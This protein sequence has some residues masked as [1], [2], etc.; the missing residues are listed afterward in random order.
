MYV[1]IIFPI[2]HLL[3]RRNQCES[4]N[5]LFLSLL[6]GKIIAVEGNSAVTKGADSLSASSCDNIAYSGF[7]G[8][9]VDERTLI[10]IS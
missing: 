9:E 5:Q 2:I 1:E 3:Q 7:G 8:V 10:E 4:D 6:N